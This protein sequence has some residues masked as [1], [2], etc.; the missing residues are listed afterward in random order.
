[1]AF[2]LNESML[3]AHSSLSAYGSGPYALPPPPY[4]H[5]LPP[6][7][8]MLDDVNPLPLMP[9]TLIPPT[10]ADVIEEFVCW[11]HMGD[12]GG[13]CDVMTEGR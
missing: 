7:A 6:V 8:P 10:P 3:L 5:A 4:G 12:G 11:K 13:A 2:F 1:M 9:G